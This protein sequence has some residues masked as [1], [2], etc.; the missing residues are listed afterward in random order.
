MPCVQVR[1]YTLIKYL[2]IINI[3]NFATARADRFK[4]V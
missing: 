2:H 4:T 3:A 1:G